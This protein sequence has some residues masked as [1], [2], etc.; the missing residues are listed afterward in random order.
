MLKHLKFVAW[1]TV[2]CGAY[3]VA[4][5]TSESKSVLIFTKTVEYEHESI[6]S[7]AKAIE[8]LL[9]ENGYKVTISGDASV[10]H[11]GLEEA[12]DILVFLNTS[13]DI[14]NDFQQKIMRQFVESG[15]GF[16]GIHA[17]TDTEYEW[18]WY[19][20]LIGAYFTDHPDVQ[21]ATIQV[22]EPRHPTTEML[23]LQW[24]RTDEWYNFDSELTEEFEMLCILDE[25]TYKGGKHKNMHPYTWC[26]EVD[27]GRM[28]YTAGGHTAECYSDQKFMD[29]LFAGIQYAAGNTESIVGKSPEVY[30]LDGNHL[31]N[32]RTRVLSG[33][34]LYLDELTRLKTQA[35][36]ALNAGVF[37]VM[38]K[39]FTPP[40]GDKHDYMSIG[41]YWWP[42]P[43]TP[44]SLPYVRRDGRVNPERN[45][46][47]KLP[48]VQMAE[49]VQTL[50]LAFFLT[51]ESKYAA[52]AKNL[53]RTWFLNDSTRMNP[54]L[55]Y[56]QAIPGRTKG[57]GIGIIDT[58]RFAPL[59]DAVEMLEY[60]K[61]WTAKDLQQLKSWFAKYLDWLLNDKL[62]EDEAAK[63][64][65]HGT[66]YDVQA[67]RI[68]LF[69][70]RRDVA[71]KILESAPKKRIN[72]Q[73][74]PSGKQLLELE[75]T[76]AFSYSVMNL[77]GLVNLAEMGEA[78]DL[79]IWDYSSGDGR[80]IHS[81]IEY[82]VPYG[83]HDKEWHYEQIHSMNDAKR[84]FLVLLKRVGD[85]YPTF[86]T[87]EIRKQID[88]AKF[89]EYPGTW[90]YPDPVESNGYN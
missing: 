16:V 29:H 54:H 41:P 58:R 87:K 49:N 34:C 75:R 10:F 18:E 38:D 78:L 6:S 23:P 15:G 33:D 30:L 9:E 84:D 85:E 19:G 2:L 57:R 69:V 66:W 70:D 7:G 47:D 83:I 79:D 89:T 28:W 20:E 62:G 74:E 56:G 5:Q 50:S 81:A 44:D 24:N 42:N 60:S 17:A 12:F 26:R 27:K 53:L 22:V 77:E 32:L 3:L 88:S 46:Y 59:L 63:K 13:G 31:L 82:L 45:A 43:D 80:D 55:E 48:L 11:S 25:S 8:S 35:D 68:A 73:I 52:Q 40:S 14:L 21:P 4:A 61:A 65:N 39:P 72:V 90:I 37:S 51:N 67:A 1:L 71:K 64:N 76:K 86:W 36:T